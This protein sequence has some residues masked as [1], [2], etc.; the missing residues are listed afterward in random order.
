M[1][2]FQKTALISP[3][4]APVAYGFM[5]IWFMVQESGVDSK[6]TILLSYKI[7]TF[8]TK[9]VDNFISGKYDVFPYKISKMKF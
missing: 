9:K 3:K 2:F 5:I 6:K 1:G 7:D 4:T 8:F